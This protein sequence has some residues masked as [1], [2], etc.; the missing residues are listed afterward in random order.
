M[1]IDASALVAILTAE[2]A[3]WKRPRPLPTLGGSPRLVL[4]G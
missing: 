4:N 1:M 3:P 2:P